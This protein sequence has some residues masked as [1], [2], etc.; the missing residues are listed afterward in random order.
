[1]D[2]TRLVTKVENLKKINMKVNNDKNILLIN[3]MK[4]NKNLSY[5]IQS[6]IKNKNL[7]DAVGNQ[8]NIKN[9]FVHKNTKSNFLNKIK[10]IFVKQKELWIYTTEQQK[11]ATDSYSRYERYILEKTKNKNVDFITIGDRAYNFC[12]QNKFNVIKDF[13]TNTQSILAFELSQIIKILYLEQNY[14]KVRFVLNTNKNFKGS[15][16]ILP[17]QE[18]DVYKLSSS[19]LIETNKLDIKDFKIFP[20]VET[21]IDNEANIF[22]E[23]VVNS[24]L[25]ESSFYTTKNALVTANKIIKDL[26]ENIMKLSRQAMRVKRQNEIEE[27]IMLTSNNKNDILSE[28]DDGK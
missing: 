3:M 8:Y 12:K 13:P 18:F 4:L 21:F 2:L 23:N 1:M 24:L 5:Y 14:R 11:Y 25:I 6:A 28:S 27:I 19:T 7:I 26:D 17:T 22:I 16:T 9:M 15:F 10:Q 20:N